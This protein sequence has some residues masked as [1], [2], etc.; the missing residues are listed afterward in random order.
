MALRFFLRFAAAKTAVTYGMEI[1]SALFNICGGV[2]LSVAG[3]MEDLTNASVSLPQELADEINSIGF[4][5]SIP[6]WLITLLGSL[7]ITVLSFVLIL[8]VYA[9]FFRLYM[10][11]ALAPIPLASFAGETTSGTGKAFIKSYLGVCMQGVVIVLACI[12]FSAFAGS[13]ATV[14]ASGT[15]VTKVWS[16]LVE[17]VFNM[18]VMVGLVKGA[19]RIIKEMMDL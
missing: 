19:D 16:Y 11:T 18:I 8:T 7:F 1:M 4:L 10:Y 15:A 2:I 13:P 14:L 6:L 9:R 5:A 3:H 12:I 17:V